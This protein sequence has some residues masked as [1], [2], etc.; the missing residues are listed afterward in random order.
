M[1]EW[2]EVRRAFGSCLVP[3][4]ARV[5]TDLG[6]LIYLVL[7]FAHTLCTDSCPLLDPRASGKVTV[8]IGLSR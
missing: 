1:F 3:V 7:I 4:I 5:L 2:V 8:D 6:S